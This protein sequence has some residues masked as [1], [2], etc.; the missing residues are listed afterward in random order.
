MCVGGGGPHKKGRLYDNKG[1][2][3]QIEGLRDPMASI[4]INTERGILRLLLKSYRLAQFRFQENRKGRVLGLYMQR[5]GLE[6]LISKPSLHFPA[7]NILVY[8][9]PPQK[10]QKQ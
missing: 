3:K 2:K 7:E 1:L 9:D 5:P 4:K 8:L 6:N 10:K